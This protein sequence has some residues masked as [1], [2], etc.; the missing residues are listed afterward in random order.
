MGYSFSLKDDLD[1]ICTQIYGANKA[2]VIEAIRKTITDTTTKTV[3]SKINTEKL[4]NDINN[5]AKVAYG[6]ELP[7]FKFS[8]DEQLNAILE[9]KLKPLVADIKEKLRGSSLANLEEVKLTS[10][11]T[12]NVSK[13]H[14]ALLALLHIS[15]KKNIDPA[16][17]SYIKSKS[18]FKAWFW[19]AHESFS[20]DNP[21]NLKLLRKKI[22]AQ[23]GLYES[24]ENNKA[25]NDTSSAASMERVSFGECIDIFT[26]LN[27]SKAM[28][29]TKDKNGK[30]HKE[31]VTHLE[32]MQKDEERS[33][34]TDSK[35]EG[36][37]KPF[38]DKLNS[39]LSSETSKKFETENIYCVN[40]TSS[41]TS[42]ASR[43]NKL[44]KR[45]EE[46]LYK[47]EDMLILCPIKTATPIR[48]F[49][50]KKSN[51]TIVLASQSEFD[52]S[53]LNPK[54]LNPS[55]PNYGKLN[56]CELILTDFKFDSYEKENKGASSDRDIKFKNAKTKSDSVILYKENDDG[57]DDKNKTKGA[58]FTSIRQSSDEIEYK[59]ED[60]VVKMSHFKLPSSKDE[61]LNFNLLNFAKENNFTLRDDKD[62][63]MFDM[64]LRLALGNNVVPTSTS[65][66]SLALTLNNLIIENEK[67]EASDIDKIYLHHCGDKNIYEST[68]LVKNKDSDI[69]NSYTATF[70]IPIDRND[71]KDT[72]LIVYSSDLSKIY[73]TKGIHAYTGTAIISIGYKDKSG[74][75]FSYTNK[76]SLRDIT[77]HIVNVVSDSE[78]PFKT[79]EEISLKA[80]Y[81]QEKG[82]KRYK[83]VLWGYMVIK[84]IEYNELS[85]K[86][87]REAVALKDQK[88]K[89][90]RFKI[91]DVIKKDHLDK[92]KQGG[93]TIVFFAYLEGEKDKFKYQSV[94]GKNHIRIDIKIPLYI[95]FKD[96]KLIIYEF[97]HAI[98][99]KSFKA[100][101]NHD[102]ALV[103]K[104]GYLYINKDMSAQDINIYEDDKLT[105]ELKSE[106]S[107][108]K[109]YQIY[110]DEANSTNYQNPSN[111]N[112]TGQT[113]INQDTKYGINLLSKDNMNSFINS[114][115]ESKSITRV[116]KGMW[117]DGDREA[118]V[119]I[120]IKDYPFTLS[121]LKQVFTNI[122]T[123]QEYILQEMV[124]ELN[125]RDDE[126]GIQMYVKYKLDT[127]N[128]LEHFF[129]QCFVEAK[130]TKGDFT[131]EE[132]LGKFT[133][134][135]IISHRGKARLEEAKKLYPQYYDKTD[136]SK[137]A[138]FVGNAMYSDRGKGY[139][140]N[141]GGDDGFNF[142]GRGI[143]QLTGKFN[144]K[145]F[146][147]YAHNN[148]WLD[149]E[150][151]FVNSPD[152]LISDGKYALVSAAYFWTIERPKPKKY[153][154]YEIADES[155]ADSDNSDIVERIT[156]VI[157]PQKL[158]LEQR[159]EAYKRIKTANVF[160]IFQ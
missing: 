21:H 5:A 78:Y 141:D 26:H 140:G 104:S 137:W 84:A 53:E 106:D 97:E 32:F 50:P 44:L 33:N 85:K 139:L 74:G 87:P 118:N 54:E 61:Y 10:S 126:D 27:I 100:S 6:T 109:R 128:R 76:V 158:S 117:V 129:G 9:S 88:G 42:N 157:N 124:D 105:K 152:L 51:F 151:N 34:S 43:I 41:S 156:A 112:Q 154:L 135:N 40:L 148:Y 64:K 108:N 77:D 121:M 159:K 2:K 130:T 115:N 127:R 37:F 56:L 66:S 80:I 18:R 119:L 91:S 47:Q 111:T 143:K 94:Y 81:K 49:Q 1:A 83:E 123:N 133:E 45:R 28:Y 46:E 20:G 138:K 103:N 39:L 7:E 136:P 63:A 150:V 160:K 62:S 79:N 92:L 113:K 147:K 11:G 57:K 122:K 38:A 114:F 125:R 70:N 48:I 29:V 22:S 134:N 24:D 146:N 142:R 155:K 17:A 19:L 149:E 8:Q 13:E 96:D 120:E 12:S 132:E 99:E 30:E 93:H 60:G 71:K 69:K 73:D 36:L 145:D 144:Y 95:K 116:D 31:D 98:K 15:S 68:S 75:S 107:T 14:V 90:I 3:V 67:G 35:C 89:E 25:L 58:C 110:I 65:S 72:K 153:R 23:F 4:F 55:R 59:L 131:L 102:D 82:S 86:Q 101:L 16:L 52:C